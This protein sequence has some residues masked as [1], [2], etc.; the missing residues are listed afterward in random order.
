[1]S[2]TLESH[3]EVVKIAR[4]LGVEPKQVEY[5]AQVPAEDLRELRDAATDVLFGAPSRS[6]DAIAAASKV[7][8]AGI[9]ANIAQRSLGPLICAR[10]V[11]R[12]DPGRAI[13]VAGKLPPA[14]LA[15][16]AIELDPRRA[17]EV[18]TRV[19]E[20]LVAAV[21]RELTKRGE[22]VTM[23]RF[24]GHISDDAIRST[25]EHMD[26]EAL[27]RTAFVTE[28]KEHI[29]LVIGMLPEERL[30]G[31]I[32]AAHEHDLWPETLDLTSHLGDELRGRLGGALQAQ[33][34]EVFVSLAEA[35]AGAQTLWPQLLS[36][37][38]AVAPE[39]R[40]QIVDAV[41]AGPTEGIAGLAVGLAD[42]AADPELVEGAIGLLGEIDPKQQKQIAAEVAKLDA[43]T[44]AR[45]RKRAKEFGVLEQ[46]HPALAEALS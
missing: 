11:S 29:D 10:V 8:P 22:H 7:V 23:G 5:L 36:L 42:A 26:D 46:L 19:P 34:H 3:A 16:V 37:A 15:D 25:F 43:K 31:I 24:L 21:A 41:L 44:R 4:L 9:S 30:A 38:A 2:A 6:L 18:I 28:N 39:Q 13:D 12:V 14:F 27:L 1:M 17:T 45:L 20:K 32:R 35:V 40:A 33:D